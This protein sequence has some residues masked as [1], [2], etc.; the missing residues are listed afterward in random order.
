MDMTNGCLLFLEG[1]DNSFSLSYPLSMATQMFA[2]YSYALSEKPERYVEYLEY[3]QF[4]HVLS[5]VWLT[6]TV[7][8]SYRRYCCCVLIQ[9]HTHTHTHTLTLTH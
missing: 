6:V 3:P 4:R 2:L 8:F 5:G 1:T 9:T 7:L